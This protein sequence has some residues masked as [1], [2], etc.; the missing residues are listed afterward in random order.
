MQYP[1]GDNAGIQMA[2]RASSQP[3]STAEMKRKAGHQ[4][5]LGE[6]LAKFE[7]FQHGWHPYSRFLDVDKID[8][9]LRR[10]RGERV[11]YREVQVK[12]GKLYDCNTKWSIALFTATSWR[13]F[14]EQ[15]L[16]SLMEHRDLFLCYVLAPDDGFKG[17]MFI[18]PIEEFVEVIR[19]SDRV[20]NGNYRVFISRSR[21][22]ESKWFVRRL[23]KFRA[24][25]AQSVI[26]VSAYYRNFDCL[27]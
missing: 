27:D 5:I 10:R 13:F 6:T 7:F 9:I 23:P 4:E 2:R 17:D 15:S 20:G 19:R 11:D 21:E 18:F 25:D 3:L 16:E 24:L 1:G 26:D 22:D 8:L 14:S 12:F